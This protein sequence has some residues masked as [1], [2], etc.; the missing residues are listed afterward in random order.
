MR[1]FR[2]RGFWKDNS[3]ESRKIGTRGSICTPI[4]WIIKIGVNDVE[5]MLTRSHLPIS[6]NILVPAI[7]TFPHQTFSITFTDTAVH[8]RRNKDEFRV[9]KTIL[10]KTIFASTMTVRMRVSINGEEY[11]TTVHEFHEIVSFQAKLMRTTCAVSFQCKKNCAICF[12]RTYYCE[13][14]RTHLILNTFSAWLD[15][16]NSI[17]DYSWYEQSSS[18]A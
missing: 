1:L 5:P 10:V 8:G 17:F 14:I 11:F 18:A 15:E 9:K 3:T 6:Q 4:S 12:L 16:L 7:N 13:P 2:R